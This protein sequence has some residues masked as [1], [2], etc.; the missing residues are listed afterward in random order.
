MGIIKA[1]NRN[2]YKDGKQ[3]VQLSKVA[4][5]VLVEWTHCNPVSRNAWVVDKERGAYPVTRSMLKTPS[6][7]PA[8]I[9][10]Q[11]GVK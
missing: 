8:K 9:R 10:Q 7:L 3:T 4:D 1:L 6:M 2:E 5:W 11:L